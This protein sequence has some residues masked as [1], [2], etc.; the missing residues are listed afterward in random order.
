MTA[1]APGLKLVVFMIIT[2][3]TTAL[4]ATV[5]GNMRFGPSRTFVGVFADASGIVPGEDVKLAG[6]PVGKVDSV[7]LAMD[8]TSVISQVTF[9]VDRAIVLTSGTTLAVKF[10]NLIGDR[11][12]EV[13]QGPGSLDALPD[14]STVP[15]DR[16]QAALDLD[17]L[18][19]GFKPLLQGLSPEDTNMF[20]SSLVQVLN[21]QSQVI[22]SL[23][24]QVG[25]LTATLADKDE[26]IGR[27]ITNLNNVLVTVDGRREQFSSMIDRLQKIVSGLSEDRV[28]VTDAIT[29]VDAV[30]ATLS[31]V[32]SE[33]RPSLQQDISQLG[34][35]SSNLNASG[36][37]LNMVLGNLPQAYKLL[38]RG[39][40]GSF[41]NFYL[42]GV[43]IKFSDQLTTP[44]VT[45]PTQRCQP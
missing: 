18:V 35:L 33:S 17:E 4:L 45:S 25:S 12:L 44:M 11:Y 27:V 40:Y 36:D 19:N 6:V 9:S 16:T 10:K 7:D 37:T 14:E 30:T 13:A 8:G 39:T 34:A 23:V 42:C 15:L 20:T 41:F 1:K 26:V 32:L 2:A 31:S 21:G 43:A 24:Q 3:L 28:R 38:G 29:D 5:V 22:G